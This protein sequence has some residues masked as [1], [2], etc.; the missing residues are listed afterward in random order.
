MK[1]PQQMR[2]ESL[3]RNAAIRLQQQEMFA[4]KQTGFAYLNKMRCD[5]KQNLIYKDYRNKHY[6]RKKGGV[7][8]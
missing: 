2:E 6:G 1:S 8:R 7:A 5:V 3:A 4:R